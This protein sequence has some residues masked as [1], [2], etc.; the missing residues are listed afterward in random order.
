MAHILGRACQAGHLTCHP[1]CTMVDIV[2]AIPRQTVMGVNLK[3]TQIFLVACVQASVPTFIYQPRQCSGPTPTRRPSRMA[4]RKCSMEVLG[5]V[6]THTSDG[7][8]EGGI[9][10][11]H[12]TLKQRHLVCF[13]PKAHIREGG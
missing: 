7:W 13:Y 1:H 11:Q 5:L 4:T 12:C 6:H 8:P 3:G 2:G 9:G 10:S